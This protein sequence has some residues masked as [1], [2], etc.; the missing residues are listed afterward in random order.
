MKKIFMLIS[1]T[2]LCVSAVFAQEGRN[3]VGGA[4]TAYPYAA[5]GGLCYQ[6]YITEKLGLEGFGYVIYNPSYEEMHLNY[7]VG[8]ELDYV[9]YEH[10]PASFFNT[11]LFLWGQLVHFG[12]INQTYHQTVYGTTTNSS[13]ETVTDYDNVITESY[14]DNPTYAPNFGAALGFGFDLIFGKHVCVPVKFGISGDLSGIGFS[15]SSGL[16]YIW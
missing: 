15:T 6:R 5:A 8:V 11:R 1:C 10:S 12:A 3:A 9:I 14:Y 7:S 16:K 13:G 4:V 2:L